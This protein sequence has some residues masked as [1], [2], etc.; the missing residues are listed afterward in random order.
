[1]EPESA[2]IPAITTDQMRHVD[3]LMVDV[4]GIGLLPMME[5]AGRNLAML[6]R[7]MLGG[8]VVKKSIVIAA[9]KGNNGGGGMVAAR[10]LSNWGAA[11]TVLLEEEQAVVGVPLLQ[12]KAMAKLPVQKREGA[13]ALR[14]L[15]EGWTD[16]VIDALIGYSLSG[17]PR[18]WPSRLIERINTLS[19]PIL[20]LDVPSGLDA[21]TGQ[22]H[23]PCVKAT[24]T[25]TLALPKTGLLKPEAT[26]YV[27]RLYLADI[28]VPD[29]LYRQMGLQ[30]GPIFTREILIPLSDL[31]Q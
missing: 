30:V 8:S 6:A 14:L 11:V 2:T 27:G 13:A 21:T 18:G 9:G 25:M 1:M 20:A 31:E 3:Q 15:G 23:N 28:G 5:N 26:P 19:V 10:H 7:T 24:A 16:L 12:L 4:F 22:A 17:A 29:A